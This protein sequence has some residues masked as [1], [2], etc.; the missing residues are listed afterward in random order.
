MQERKYIRVGLISCIALPFVFA[1][2]SGCSKPGES[3]NRKAPLLLSVMISSVPGDQQERISIIRGD[4]VI[5]TSLIAENREDKISVPE[6]AL[7]S[8]TVRLDAL[9]NAK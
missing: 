3:R 9:H 7:S 5:L 8:L 2:F 6:D 1:L 4:T